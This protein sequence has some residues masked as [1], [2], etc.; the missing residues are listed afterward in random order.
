MTTVTT[1]AAL[2]EWRARTRAAGRR[3]VLVPTM[4]ALHDGH[5]RLIE[6]ARD[7]GDEVVVSIFVNPLQ[8]GPAEDLDR[9]PRTLRQDQAAATAHGATMI[10]APTAAEMYPGGAAT[11]VHPGAGASRWE[12]EVR[13][14]H[15]VGVLTVVAKLFHLIEPD[16]AVFGQKDIQQVTLIRR[17]VEDLNLSVEVVV[18]PTVREADGLA[19]SSRNVYLSAT[20]R[21]AATALSRGLAAAVAAWR[22]GE[23]DAARLT[24]RVAAILAAEPG[25]EVDYIAIAEP[26]ALAPVSEASPG[27]VLAV[28]ARLGSTRLIDNVIL[29]EQDV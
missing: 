22:H 25:V 10:F 8:F 18:V 2:R 12:G 28:A 20:D 21:V 15:F 16:V 4:G 23:R 13:P 1:I 27:T 29:E 19:M 5:L 6:V 26:M 9:Y 3:V 11:T 14:G 24:A 7:R 17:M